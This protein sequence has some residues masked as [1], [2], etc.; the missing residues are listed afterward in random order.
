MNYCETTIEE[1][2]EN[3]I[4]NKKNECK[5]AVLLGAGMPTAKGIMKDIEK[6]IPTTT[7][8]GTDT[9]YF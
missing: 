6:N 9:Y 3:L 5:T 1:I 4:I 2:V 7:I 8:I